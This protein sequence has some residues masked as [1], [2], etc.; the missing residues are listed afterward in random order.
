MIGRDAPHRLGNVRQHEL[1]GHIS[2]RV[3]MRDCRLH[4]LIDRDRAAFG[5]AYAS[6]F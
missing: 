6:L 1:G 4:M 2:N 3:D 5:Q